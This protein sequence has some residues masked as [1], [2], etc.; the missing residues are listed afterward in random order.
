V[1]NGGRLTHRGGGRSDNGTMLLLL[2]LLLLNASS[3]PPHRLAADGW[4][5]V[6]WQAPSTV[7]PI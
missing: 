3:L 2:L 4:C 7:R 1:D 6:E 5:N